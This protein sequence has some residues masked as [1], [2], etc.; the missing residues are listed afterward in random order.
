M[1]AIITSSNRAD[2]ASTVAQMHRDRKTVFVDGLK[3]DVPVVDGVYEMDE[4]DTE[5]AVY[6][7]A[8]DPATGAHLGSVRL[9]CTAGPHLLGDKF[10]FL[11]AEAVPTGNDVWE[12]TRLCTTPGLSPAFA[13]QIRMTLVMALMEYGLA[14]D[15]ARYTMMTRMSYLAT[16]LAVGWDAEPLGFPADIAGESVGALQ[17]GVD[18]ATLVRLRKM[19]GFTRSVLDAAALPSALAA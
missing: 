11:C 8:A 2:H 18:D 6:L 16:L 19:Y 9:V 3:W 10:A 17:I 5:D 12:I 4:Y 14:N 15:I 13:L 7:I 1:V